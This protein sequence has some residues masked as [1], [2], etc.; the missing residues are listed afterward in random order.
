MLSLISDWLY[1]LTLLAIFGSSMMAGLYFVFSNFALR[2]FHSI[3]ASAGIAAMQAINVK[4][5]NPLF[6]LL[7]LGTPIL[8]LLLTIHALTNL[9]NQNNLLLLAGS[10]IH[11]FGSLVVTMIF[12]IPYNNRLASVDATSSTAVAVWD[13]Y[14][15]GWTR[16]N[17]VRTVSSIL[18]ALLL[19]ITK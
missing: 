16:W 3:T 2:A 17:H 13:D 6:L 4:I 9:A 14:V 5:V 12:N 19:L 8:C 15:V 1:P 10:L 11:I 18:A 7:F